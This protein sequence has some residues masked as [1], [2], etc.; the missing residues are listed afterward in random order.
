[1]KMKK[2][3]CASLAVVMAIG[4]LSGCGNGSSG[5]NTEEFKDTDE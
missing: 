4:M 5:S 2:L 3:L 1:M